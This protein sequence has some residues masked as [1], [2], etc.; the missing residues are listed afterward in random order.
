MRS[1]SFICHGQA[2]PQVKEWRNGKGRLAFLPAIGIRTETKKRLEPKL[3]S[4]HLAEYR[5]DSFSLPCQT[6]TT[7]LRRWLRMLAWLPGRP[8]QPPPPVYY[9]PLIP[10]DTPDA[11][12]Y[13]LERYGAQLHPKIR[14]KLEAEEHW[15]NQ[16]QRRRRS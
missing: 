7:T 4:P 13:L 11:R 6:K 10:S 5:D 9:V 8:P 16:Q 3:S 12:R 2:R 15:H 14:F 1:A